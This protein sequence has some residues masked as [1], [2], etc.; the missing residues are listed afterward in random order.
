MGLTG[1]AQEI[2]MP[3]HQSILEIYNDPDNSAAIGRTTYWQTPIER[4]GTLY[5]SLNA[6]AFRLLVPRQHEGQIREMRTASYCVVAR[7][8]IPN[9]GE[10][11][12]LLFDDGS[13][14][15]YHVLLDIRACDRVPLDQNIGGPYT[16]SVWTHLVGDRCRMALTMPCYYRRS[17]R[18]PDLRPWPA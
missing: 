7:G 3:E 5:L 9:A 2:A 15:P 10:G 11:I 8:P 18:L 13:R 6:N 14:H 1:P 4:A 16:L 12:G 17:Q